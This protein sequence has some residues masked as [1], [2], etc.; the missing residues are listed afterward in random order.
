MKYVGFFVFVICIPV[1]GCL[2]TE[3]TIE[4]KGKVLDENTRILIPRRTII[5]E[6]LVGSYNK[7]IP[8]HAG[9]FSTDLSGCFTYT[10]R[11]VKD[12]YFYNFCLVG[13]SAYAFS[14]NKLDLIEISKDGMFLSFYLRK[15]TD[16][17]IT[18]ERKSKTPVRDTLYV[19]WVSDEADGKTLYQDQIEN[20]GVPPD[21]RYRWIGGNVKSV[22]RTKT[23]ADKKT[24]VC[25]ELFR[26]GK[27]KEISETIFCIRDIP[28]YVNFKY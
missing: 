1:F 8:V 22:I 14:I 5:V 27:K 26:N 4:I 12:A 13:D 28:N 3:G 18:I 9:Q 6:G 2:N 23:Y 10:L 20:Y 19:S 11:K 21:I 7:L 25:F 16:F 17:A 24:I 15:L